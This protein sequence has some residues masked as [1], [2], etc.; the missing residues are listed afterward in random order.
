MFQPESCKSSKFVKVP[1]Y[2]KPVSKFLQHAIRIV[3]E[4]K[5]PAGQG[6]HIPRAHVAL[7]INLRMLRHDDFRRCEHTGQLNI[8]AKATIGGSRDAFE[9]AP[10][11]A[12]VD[13][14]LAQ[15]GGRLDQ[16]A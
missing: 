8:G 1:V 10:A 5:C 11:V 16:I 6:L 4:Y 3:A 7:G 12:A 13:V 15:A 14:E 9:F 2:T